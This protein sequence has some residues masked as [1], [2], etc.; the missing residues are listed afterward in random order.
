MGRQW[1]SRCKHCGLHYSDPVTVTHGAGYDWADTSTWCPNPDCGQPQE[2]AQDY[3][4]I[5]RPLGSGRRHP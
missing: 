1:H 4:M 5:E 3:E 2:S